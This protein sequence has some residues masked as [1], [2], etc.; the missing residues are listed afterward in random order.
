MQHTKKLCLSGLTIALYNVLMYFTQS[1]S[2]GQY[3]VR[4][5]TGLYSLTYYFPFLCMPLGLANMLS[6]ILF[7]GDLINGIF[8]FIAGTLT[9][10]SICLTKKFTTKKLI[11]VAPIAL[12]PSLIIPIWLSY[13]LQIPYFYLV[14]S[15][16]IGQTISA[17]TMGLLVLVAAEQ[18]KQW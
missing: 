13:T 2:F 14:V 11:V 10:V 17:Y 7:G 9:C 15:L 18:V 12:M 3:Q 6:N 16:F 4:L 1:F 5:A 8:G